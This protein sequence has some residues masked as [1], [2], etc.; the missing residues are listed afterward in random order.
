[1]ASVFADIARGHKRE[2]RDLFLGSGAMNGG[3][4]GCLISAAP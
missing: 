2:Y 1:V 3:Y 4:V